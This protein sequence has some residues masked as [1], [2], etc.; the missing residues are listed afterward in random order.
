MDS[1]AGTRTPKGVCGPVH[2][3]VLVLAALIGVAPFAFGMFSKAPDQG[4]T[5]PAPAL[6]VRRI[7]FI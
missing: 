6:G 1:T 5:P 4:T 7:A 3:W 2:R